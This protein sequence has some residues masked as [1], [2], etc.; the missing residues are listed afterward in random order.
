M[1]Q[2]TARHRRSSA[3]DPFLS[4]LWNYRAQRIGRVANPARLG[5]G[6]RPAQLCFAAA[7]PRF[8]PLSG[9]AQTLRGQ[10]ACLGHF[11]VNVPISCQ[12][13]TS[14]PTPSTS[15]VGD[16]GLYAFLQPRRRGGLTSS[17]K[18]GAHR[19]LWTAFSA[20]GRMSSASRIVVGVPSPLRPASRPVP[21]VM[22]QVGN[23]A[24]LLG[25]ASGNPDNVVRSAFSACRRMRRAPCIVTL[26]FRVFRE[27]HLFFV[28][29]APRQRRLGFSKPKFM[30]NP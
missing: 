12:D 18:L 13:R 17:A 23:A 26:V 24:R 15:G 16:K 29:D 10:S 11:E 19:A 6:I 7:Q 28:S 20:E 27:K 5:Q 21:R 2:A 30:K 1:S 9:E 8:I 3:P 14:P 25:P 22:W 4:A